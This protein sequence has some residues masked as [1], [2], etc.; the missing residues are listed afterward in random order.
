MKND[1]ST[2]QKLDNIVNILRTQYGQLNVSRVLVYI[3]SGRKIKNEKL[4]MKCNTL[5][6]TIDLEELKKE[7]VKHALK[8]STTSL[9]LS[10]RKYCDEFVSSLKTNHVDYDKALEYALKDEKTMCMLTVAFANQRYN[11]HLNSF[12]IN[13]VKDSEIRKYIYYLEP[14]NISEK[15][16]NNYLGRVSNLLFNRSKLDVLCDLQVKANHKE[17][18]LGK[19]LFASTDIGKKAERQEDAVLLLEH[20]KNKDFKLLAV[21]DGDSSKLFGEQASN[22]VLSSILKWF[23]TLDESLYDNIDDLK[24]LIN[25]KLRQINIELSQ[26]RDDRASTFTCAIIG[27]NKTLI[28]SIG[29]SRA[30][31]LKNHK[32]TRVTRDDSYIQDLCD[33]GYVKEELSRFHKGS[34]L[35]N[36]LLGI[37]EYEDMLEIETKCIPNKY[38][39][40]IIVSDGVT[41]CI[42]DE[43]ILYLSQHLKDKDVARVLV[44]TSLNTESKIDKIRYGYNETIPAG[45]ENSTAAVYVKKLKLHTV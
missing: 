24:A 38:E 34:K 14:T 36:R 20:P 18:K 2:L 23:E 30:Y 28:S 39:K 8:V 5:F 19:S 3:I 26:N 12:E 43:K 29:D 15:K 25:N 41:K 11:D 9:E 16:H 7:I 37:K 33:A 4:K 6:S 35:V 22:Y 27:K 42:D 31:T 44:N 21:A 10:N 40:I 1:M 17:Y 45:V 13:P 32:L